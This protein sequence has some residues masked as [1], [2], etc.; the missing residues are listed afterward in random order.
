MSTAIPAQSLKKYDVV[1]KGRI[2][3]GI[4]YPGLICTLAERYQFQS[5]GGTSAGAIAAALTAAAEFARRKG[6][7]AFS[8]GA[9]EIHQS[10]ANGSP[11]ED[12]LQAERQ[13]LQ[14]ISYRHDGFSRAMQEKTEN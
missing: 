6:R 9:Y 7:D 13:V 14:E 1:M 5:I 11:L 12:W 10:K 8:D 3:S 4:V 2:S